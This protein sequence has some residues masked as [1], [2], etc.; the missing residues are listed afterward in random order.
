MQSKH[1][2][3]LQ[4]LWRPPF[5]AEADYP[6]LQKLLD[7]ATHLV[8]RKR[9]DFE[10]RFSQPM[11]FL[12]PKYKCEAAKQ[13]LLR[14]MIEK[15]I[16]SPAPVDLRRLIFSSSGQLINN[17]TQY[18][19]EMARVGSD[20]FRI[21]AADQLNL[22]NNTGY[23]IDFAESIQNLYADIP[24]ERIIESLPK[25]I[26][27]ASLALATNGSLVSRHLRKSQRVTIDLLGESRRVVRQA[28]FRGLLCQAEKTSFGAR[29]SIS[30]PLSVIRHTTYYGR[31]L[32]ELVPFLSWCPKYRLIAACG[33]SPRTYSM[34][35]MSGDPLP[36]ASTQPSFDSKIENHFYRDFSKISS[37][38]DLIRE[39]EPI[40]I[41]AKPGTAARL[42]FPDFAAIQRTDPT[43]RWL[44]EIV[45]YWSPAYLAAKL[46][47]FKS[48][49]A[50]RVLLCIDEKLACNDI[51]LPEAAA[52][53]RFKKRINAREVMERLT[54]IDMVHK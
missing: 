41:N 11:P 45:G 2:K 23:P 5:L 15:P 36:A 32:A 8:G 3:P 37:D 19:Y 9:S 26:S 28:K 34:V 53:I 50:S 43:K 51:P 20:A 47:D 4:P 18:G 10:R 30:G 46:E 39:P 35:I 38:W 31:A 54:H 42:I 25:D 17:K 1:G 21:K 16:A 44:I 49:N 14:L 13:Q 7:Q 22:L 27:P 40:E 52:I 29:L 6:W 24:S 48:M 12:A 33:E